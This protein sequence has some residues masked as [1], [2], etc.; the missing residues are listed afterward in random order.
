M[1]ETR[2]VRP[3]KRLIE[4]SCPN[5][6]HVRQIYDNAASGVAHCMYCG[7][8]YEWNDIEDALCKHEIAWLP[9]LIG[10]ALVTR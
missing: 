5:C 1:V 2:L 3:A 4:A 10:S 9:G 7:A 8:D 6:R